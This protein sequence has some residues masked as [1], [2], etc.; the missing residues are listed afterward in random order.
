MGDEEGGRRGFIEGQAASNRQPGLPF[1]GLR[2]ALGAIQQK[3]LD[4]FRGER[5]EGDDQ[6]EAGPR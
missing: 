2:L 4:F 5:Q 6:R 3:Y 1:C